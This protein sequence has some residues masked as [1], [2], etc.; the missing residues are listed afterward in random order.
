M[1]LSD[2]GNYTVVITTSAGTTTSSVATLT[3]ATPGTNP[4]RLINLS[5]RSNAGAGAKTPTLPR[6]I[7]ASA[8]TQVGT[9]ADILIAGFV[10]GARRR[11]RCSSARS[12]RRSARLA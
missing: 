5:I 10:V 9:G 6:L 4:G 7:N 2:A 12:G 11:A 1:Q 3:V 8:R